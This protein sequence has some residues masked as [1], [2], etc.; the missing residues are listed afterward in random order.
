MNEPKWYTLDPSDPSNFCVKLEKHFANTPLKDSVW[1]PLESIHWPFGWAGGNSHEDRLKGGDDLYQQ[2]SQCIHKNPKARIHLISHSHGGNVVL[3]ALDTY[4]INLRAILTMRLFNHLLLEVFI[5][6]QLS[7]D[8]IR[9]IILKVV[10]QEVL[11]AWDAMP[12]IFE[13]TEQISK[14]FTSHF[15]L[16]WF[17]YKYH[18][19][20]SHISEHIA[21][22]LIRLPEVNRIGRLVFLGTPFYQ[23]T[24]TRSVWNRFLFLVAKVAVIIFWWII[25]TFIIVVW[26]TIFMYINDLQNLWTSISNM[27]LFLGVLAISFLLTLKFASL[28]QPLLP[29]K[30]GNVYFTYNDNQVETKDKK[31]RPFLHALTIHASLLDEAFVALASDPLALGPLLSAKLKPNIK[32]PMRPVRMSF[33]RAND[34][35]WFFLRCGG[36]IIKIIHWL[37]YILPSSLTSGLLLK[38]MASAGYGLPMQ[39][40]SNANIEVTQTIAIPDVFDEE[41]FDAVQVLL[42]CPPADIQ[43]GLSKEKNGAIERFEFLWNEK[44]LIERAASSNMWKKISKNLPKYLREYSTEEANRRKNQLM[45]TTIAIEERIQELVGLVELN[46]S[47]YYSNTAV[48]DRIARFLIGYSAN[49]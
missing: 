24:W 23:K 30:N 31:R 5:K 12:G 27:P 16:G 28:E 10:G 39:E 36:F 43:T 20:I 19:S 21:E 15:L 33:G 22:I 6:K 7:N 44:K 11:N 8:A 41:V 47:L 49:D 38:I 1:R 14:K 17:P 29:F 35:L 26:P 3:N 32:L 34:I 45:R 25:F 18:L 46:H 42:T 48:V 40:M 2:I 37:I 13:E 9:Q 4:L